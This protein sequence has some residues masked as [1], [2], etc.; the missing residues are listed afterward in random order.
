MSRIPVLLI[1]LLSGSVRLSGAR[2]SPRGDERVS[3]PSLTILAIGDAGET[4]SAL[5]GNA[6]IM[7]DMFTGRHDG[8][9]FQALLFL[10]DN[11]YN[12]GLNVPAPE[13]EGK[14]KSILGPFKDVFDG[15]GRVNVHAIPGNHDYY[16]RNALEASILFGLVSVAEA[17]VGISSRGNEREAAIEW[18]SYHYSLPAQVTLPIGGESRDS[19]QFIFFDSALPLR[20]DPKSW[21]PALDSL[22]RLL[23][24]SR[25]RRGIVWR[26]FAAHHPFSSVGEHG[27]YSVWDDELNRVDYLPNCDRDSNAVAWIKNWLDPQDLCTERYKQY[28]DSVGTI[29][30]A[31]GVRIQAALSGHEHSLQLLYR[32]DRTGDDLSPAVQIISGAGSKPARVKF[33]APPFEFTSA[34]SAPDK[35]GVSLPGFVQ[36]SFR[37]NR[38]RIVFFNA[39][40]GDPIDMGGGREEFWVDPEG[41]LIEPDTHHD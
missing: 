33:P 36:L 1:V 25:E 18:W 34:Q 26:I 35:E 6:G 14:V 40:T 5:R 37:D 7:T 22:S 24:A 20:T 30:R 16:R 29:L 9:K 12:T 2:P 17:P 10:G 31:G 19:V 38:M 15:L 39:K 21:R 27:G 13:V 4:G 11:F 8:G 23:A 32:P 3:A 28:L 41:R